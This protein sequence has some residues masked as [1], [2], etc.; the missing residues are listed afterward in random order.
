M[1]ITLEICTYQ[2]HVI[3]Y[4]LDVNFM[5][6]ICLI[7]WVQCSKVTIFQRILI[8]YQLNCKR[9]SVDIGSASNVIIPL[10]KC[11]FFSN[12]VNVSKDRDFSREKG[13]IV[14]VKPQLTSI[15][16]VQ[17]TA[18]K[19]SPSFFLFFYLFFLQCSNSLHVQSSVLKT[20]CH[21]AT[22]FGRRLG[23]GKI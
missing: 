8:L 20:N 22:K 16:P 1:S 17:S 19:V 5:F 18:F 11:I 13:K 10:Y 12:L 15:R 9:I 14:C 21:R 3:G 4:G 23:L 7:D 6:T 2:S